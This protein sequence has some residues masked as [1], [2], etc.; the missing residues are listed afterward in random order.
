MHC[1]YVRSHGFM[2]QIAV[3][4]LHCKLC[5]KI[6]YTYFFYNAWH[7]VW[8]KDYL[9]SRV[10]KLIN[11][12]KNKGNVSSFM[13]YFFTFLKLCALKLFCTCIIL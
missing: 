6:D 3:S 13:K 8:L 2:H 7:I 11:G 1:N 9:L 10:F 12:Y 5:E 4:D